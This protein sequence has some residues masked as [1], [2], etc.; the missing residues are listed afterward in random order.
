MVPDAVTAV[1][2]AGAA[3]LLGYAVLAARRA[4]RPAALEAGTGPTYF[5][6]VLEVFADHP[7]VELVLA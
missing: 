7:E 5:D 1:R 3:F 4:L 2:I 6:I